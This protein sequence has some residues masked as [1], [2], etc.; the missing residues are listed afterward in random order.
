MKLNAI[1]RIKMKTNKIL[2]VLIIILGLLS[3]GF[4]KKSPENFLPNNSLSTTP[5][6]AILGI[7]LREN[8]PSDKMEF[9]PNAQVKRYFDDILQYSDTYS[10]TNECGGDTSQD[11]RL[12]LKTISNDGIIN[13]ETINNLDGTQGGAL[14]LMNDKGQIIIYIKQ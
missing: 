1:K 14:S 2:P 5:E 3:C 12:F 11:E 9:L 4:S 13:C 6:Q 10:I 7:W 8:V